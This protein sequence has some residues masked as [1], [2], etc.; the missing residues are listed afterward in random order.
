MSKPPATVDFAR[1]PAAL[2]V[3]AGRLA[4]S[5]LHE[6][7]G[8]IGALPSGIRPLD[9]NM[10]CC[11]PA[12][13][14]KGPPGDNLW[15]HHA[16]AL[17]A[18]G[19][20]IVADVGGL[21]EAGYWGEVMTTQAM[22]RKLGGLVIDGGVRDAQAMIAHGFPTF[23]RCISMRGTAKDRG[24]AGKLG[25]TIALGEAIISA[26]DLVVGDG[27]GV[28]VIPRDRLEAAVAAG[29][30]REEKEA[31]AMEKLRGGAMTV[32]MYGWR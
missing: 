14:V 28:V 20:V 10:R 23:S 6:A 15:L 12:F 3:R 30:A 26:G 5:T 25:V 4:T 13:T 18:P 24:F 32:D 17:A 29:E 19:D 7:A 9:L 2:M 27:D 1:P 16:L 11:G 8:Q 22:A 21:H 31:A